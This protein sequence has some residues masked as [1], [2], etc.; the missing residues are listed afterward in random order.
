M[1]AKTA[2]DYPK[3]WA[4]WCK[5]VTDKRVPS[6]TK[7][8]RF[9]ARYRAARIFHGIHCEPTANKSRSWEQGFSALL[10]VF[11]AYTAAETLAKSLPASHQVFR[12]N[13]ARIESMEIARRLR[14]SRRLFHLL[15]AE[16][17]T[18]GLRR[19]LQASV[20]NNSDDVFCVAS[21]I[22][23]LVA[24]GWITAGGADA[25]S[26]SSQQCLLDLANA[27]LALCDEKFADFCSGRLHTSSTSAVRH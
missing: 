15:I 20:D 18:E 4:D 5:A 27:V 7:L 11:L 17:D 9:A 2:G 8:N 16:V 6:S 26:I 13:D 3:H 10:K 25:R 24:H 1:A 19:R 22:R 23:H 14:S 12:L 21:A